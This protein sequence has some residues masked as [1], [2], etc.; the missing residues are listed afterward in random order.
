[1]PKLEGKDHAQ[2]LFYGHVLAALGPDAEAHAGMGLKCSQ[3]LDW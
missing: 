3:W 1:V 2:I